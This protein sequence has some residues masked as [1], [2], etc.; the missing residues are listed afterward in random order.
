MT[1]SPFDPGG[2]LEPLSAWRRWLQQISSSPDFTPGQLDEYREL[3]PRI[4]NL[5]RHGHWNLTAE[6]REQLATLYLRQAANWPGSHYC[7]VMLATD[8]QPASLQLWTTLLLQ[9]PP[10]TERAAA[11]AF[12]PLVG[13]LNWD[14]SNLFPDLL[15]GLNQLTLAP[16][17]L[18]LANL[19]VRKGRV[20]CHPAA[21][22]TEFLTT[23]L[24]E[25]SNR[26]G[27]LEEKIALGTAGAGMGRQ[28][29]ESSSLA[30]SCIDAL[31]L[32]GD[33]RALPAI[34]KAS[35]VAHRR[36]QVEAASALARFQQPAGTEQLMKLST[37]PLV[38]LRVLAYASELGLLDQIPAEMRSA[39]SRA[40]GELIQYLAQPTQFGLPP[41]SW[42]LRDQRK[43]Y[44][45]GF[46][47]RM[48][49]FLFDYAYPQAPLGTY[50][51]VALVG[52]CTRAP[53]LNLPALTLRQIYAYFAGW[54]TEHPEIRQ[55][56][57][58][59]FGPAERS[60][61]EQL[62]QR[63]P[64]SLEV[65][66]PLFVGYF[67]DQV[68]L[69]A[70]GL[71]HSGPTLQTGSLVLSA[72]QVAWF[73][74]SSSPQRLTATD[75]YHVVKGERLLAAFNSDFSTDLSPNGSSPEEGAPP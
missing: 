17:V 66:Q 50:A 39:Q 11:E 56:P 8:H 54:Q 6:A 32:I 10:A 63:L 21:S 35:D 16:L 53:R 62:L 5:I 44:W 49:V 18:D 55:V 23:L 34:Y 64:A 25:L 22:R 36:L 48:D 9:H 40:E 47:E 45:P 1:Q 33:E 20:N 46:E 13:T 51:N 75:W 52:P 27:V 60:I 70:T 67:P 2:T 4:L 72:E 68:D 74:D 26:L 3:V 14:P 58:E 15:E 61:V 24:G 28:I 43:W 19:L 73:P 57:R 65:D 37:E 31:A 30:V 38:R 69:V 12:A 41:L 7:L 29:T 71:D 42:S 59:L